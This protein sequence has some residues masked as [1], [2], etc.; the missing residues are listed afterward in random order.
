LISKLS[1][2]TQK[3]VS[4]AYLRS[5]KMPDPEDPGVLEWLEKSEYFDSTIETVNT[6]LVINK[7]LQK[8]LINQIF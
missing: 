4:L 7:S 5:L 2:T 1:G 8:S 3:Y 6:K